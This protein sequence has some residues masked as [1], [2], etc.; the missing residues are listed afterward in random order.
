MQTRF[1]SSSIES[2]SMWEPGSRSPFT[3]IGDDADSSL[4]TRSFSKA[5]SRQNWKRVRRLAT[6]L[7]E[8]FCLTAPTREGVNAIRAM[9]LSRTVPN[10]QGYENAVQGAVSDFLIVRPQKL[11][12]R[13]RGRCH[14]DGVAV[15]VGDLV[16]ATDP[17]LVDPLTAARTLQEAG[18]QITD[19]LHSSAA[20]NTLIFSDIAAIVD[21]G[22][23]SPESETV[24]AKIA[25]AFSEE[26]LGEVIWHTVAEK[27]IAPTLSLEKL[28]QLH[29]S[30]NPD[31]AELEIRETLLPAVDRYYQL[32]RDD[33]QEFHELAATFLSPL[34][35]WADALPDMDEKAPLADL[36]KA[37]SG[38]CLGFPDETMQVDMGLARLRRHG[39]S[40][41]RL[42]ESL[43]HYAPQF[44]PLGLDEEME[45]RAEAFIDD[46]IPELALALS[47]SDLALLEGV[48]AAKLRKVS[49]NELHDRFDGGGRRYGEC[50]VA[51]SQIRLYQVWRSNRVSNNSPK[52]EKPDWPA[53][54]ACGGLMSVLSTY[55]SEGF[56][57]APPK[58]S[59]ES[60]DDPLLKLF[61]LH[62][63][64]LTGEELFCEAKSAVPA[65]QKQAAVKFRGPLPPGSVAALVAANLVDRVAEHD[66]TAKSM[67]T[68]HYNLHF[69]IKVG[70][71]PQIAGHLSTNDHQGVSCAA[72]LHAWCGISG[73]PFCRILEWLD[74]Q[75]ADWVGNFVD[76]ALLPVEADQNGRF[77]HSLKNGNL[78]HGRVGSAGVPVEYYRPLDV[79]GGEYPRVAFA[80][81]LV[82]ISEWAGG[83]GHPMADL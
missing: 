19:I 53:S 30:G 68:E 41:V 58:V 59:H 43:R 67:E 76:N 74:R 55:A 79:K 63:R 75:D 51:N 46:E 37:W 35:N 17:M 77:P 2:R 9:L 40:L 11:A 8:A 16:R 71:S 5:I 22:S 78:E 33:V 7:L 6:E 69:L 29:A 28:H 24:I 52:L 82:G 14:S 3:L 49:I 44:E 57:G 38:Y 1:H 56:I 13:F 25:H 66:R 80:R 15:A 45:G 65:L 48:R 42:A 20:R 12:W 32:V 72:R 26:W 62:A 73:V 54:E 31:L 18:D 47:L 50:S 39:F 27:G 60:A 64:A 70:L 23:R 10:P 81:T 83:M 34:F 36:R 4:L 61:V 21:N